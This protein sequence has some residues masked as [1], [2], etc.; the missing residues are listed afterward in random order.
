VRSVRRSSAAGPDRAVSGPA[1]AVT[2]IAVLAAAGGLTGC[3]STQQKAAR[4]RVN[5]ERILASQNTTRVTAA[6]G[7]V[8]VERIALVR[9]GRRTAF[10]V[11][12]ENPGPDPVS[13]L[14]ISV[15]YHLGRGRPIYLNTGSDGGYFD[16]HLPAVAARGSLIWVY[17][18][19]RELPPRARP[20]AVVGARPSV[21]GTAVTSAPAI[22]AAARDGDGRNPV[23]V[24]V[25]N[26][27]GVPQFQLPVY[28]I[29]QRDGRTVAAGNASVP[30]LAGGASQ[31]L[32]LQLVGRTARSQVA[33]EAPPTIFR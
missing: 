11:T 19:G 32:R 23:Q 22:R 33:V 31:T 13:D 3:V 20:F 18:A 15:G 27:S 6:G 28:V 2:A 12:V 17:T 25:R 1:R 10:A 14:P 30:E 8:N 4:L 21:R 24:A 9:S 16:A 26:L 29:A 7:A 5:S